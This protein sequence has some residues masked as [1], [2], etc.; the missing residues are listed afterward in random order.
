MYILFTLVKEKEVWVVLQCLRGMLFSKFSFFF[1]FSDV[2]HSIPMND[3][4][5]RDCLF[6]SP[7]GDVY[8]LCSNSHFQALTVYV[9]HLNKVSA[10][11]QPPLA[12]PNC[13]KDETRPDSSRWQPTLKYVEISPLQC[14]D[15]MILCTDDAE[16]SKQ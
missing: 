14:T 3:R 15:K 9:I 8:F 5:P 16:I 11:T 7:G 1:F 2:G 10:Q 12:P 6:L 4:Q 13:L